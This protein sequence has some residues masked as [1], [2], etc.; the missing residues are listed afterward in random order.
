MK[1]RIQ[2]KFHFLSKT[3]QKIQDSNKHFH[4]KA[5]KSTLFVLLV[6]FFTLACS[7]E[8]ADPLN[9]WLGTWNGTDSWT[10]RYGSCSPDVIPKSDPFKL[11]ITKS[12]LPD[13][14]DL[15]CTYFKTSATV[16]GNTAVATNISIYTFTTPLSL[17]DGKITFTYNV[18]S[19]SCTYN[20]FTTNFNYPHDVVLSR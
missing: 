11:I 8:N 3:I 14:I 18:R 13:Q 1:K 5:S 9:Q 19:G 17:T 10:L 16:S 4:M 6:L 15:S 12:V 2:F 20:G 7:K